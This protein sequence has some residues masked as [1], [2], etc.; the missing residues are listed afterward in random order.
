MLSSVHDYSGCRTP[1]SRDQ[2]GRG[3][4]RRALA[5][6]A[7]LG[8]ESSGPLT[9]R[10][11]LCWLSPLT[12]PCSVS[13][14][15]PMILHWLT[16]AKDTQFGLQDIVHST[17]WYFYR[18]IGGR[19]PGWLAVA[20]GALIHCLTTRWDGRCMHWQSLLSG[21][22][23]QRLHRGGGWLLAGSLFAVYP[24]HMEAVGWIAAQWDQWATMFGLLGL[25]LYSMWWRQ[26]APS[27]YAVALLCYFLQE[28]SPKTVC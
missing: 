27:L 17:G 11:C 16:G 23:W 5:Y 3:R 25:W 2:P 28:Y 12:L 18:P 26:G 21:Y 19:L 22:G 9:G 7:W 20:C 6:R 15:W 4:R 14:S 24:L 1:G 10:W 8:F 13:A